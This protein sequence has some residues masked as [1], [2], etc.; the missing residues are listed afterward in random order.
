MAEN[1]AEDLSQCPIYLSSIG[2]EVWRPVPDCPNYQASNMGRFKR[3]AKHLKRKNDA[4]YLVPELIM[5]QKSTDSRGYYQIRVFDNNGNRITYS[6]HRLTALIF[7]PNPLNLPQ[8]NHKKGIKKDNRACELE[9]I[10]HQGN[11]DHAVETGLMKRGG[12][13]P[14]SK[15]VLD[16]QTGIY[17]ESITEAAIAK[18]YK[19]RTLHH[20]LIG[21]R[22]N[23]SSLILV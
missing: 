5:A 15:L 19:N 16:L 8:V 2:I 3:L 23:R 7:I 9:W 6:S 4:G 22:A 12:Q 20:W 18:D 21:D 10:T 14:Y 11:I 13:L 1:T 17:Y